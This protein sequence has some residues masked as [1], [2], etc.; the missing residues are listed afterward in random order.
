MATTDQQIKCETVLS[1]ALHDRSAGHTPAKLAPVMVS[2]IP[3]L[4]IYVALHSLHSLF[5]DAQFEFQN[6]SVV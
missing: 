3:I 4:C 2:L 6:S 5:P 1:V